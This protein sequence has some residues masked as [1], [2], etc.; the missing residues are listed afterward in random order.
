[1]QQ[2][3]IQC[4]VRA[5]D[6][7]VLTVKSIP[8]TVRFYTQVLGMRG[9]QFEATDGTRRWALL[10]GQ[11]KINLHQKGREFE[12]KAAH[13]QPGTVDV[14][15]LTDAPIEAWTR[16]LTKHQ[17]ELE[18]GPVRR[19]GAKGPITSLYLRDPDQNL[20]EVSVPCY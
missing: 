11:S 5:L 13:A 17:I 2:S 4:R 20:I 6:H 15:F 8:E 7:L 12:P 19:S 1:M 16:H 14:C 3:E 18:D 10:F 9:E